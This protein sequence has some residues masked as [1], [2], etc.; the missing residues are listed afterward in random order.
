MITF[1]PPPSA[2]RATAKLYR[3]TTGL[4]L[5]VR[6]PPRDTAATP[7]AGRS[8]GAAGLQ[9]RTESLCTPPPPSE[10]CGLRLNRTSGGRCGSEA[11]SNSDESGSACARPDSLARREDAERRGRRPGASGVRKLTQPVRSPPAAER[12]PPAPRGSVW[13]RSGA[14][15]A[16]VRLSGGGCTGDRGVFLEGGGHAQR[17][18]AQ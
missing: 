15:L 13:R 3:E 7:P 16:V 8:G 14:E 17:C 9:R 2:R 1:N 12:P 4:C 5:P 6:H 11:G 18:S 10:A